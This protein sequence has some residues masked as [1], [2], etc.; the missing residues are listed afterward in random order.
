VQLHQNVCKQ[1]GKSAEIGMTFQKRKPELGHL[2]V[3]KLIKSSHPPTPS[4]SSNLD[5]PSPSNSSTHTHTRTRAHARAHTHTHTHKI[6]FSTSSSKLIYHSRV[7]FLLH[8]YLSQT[9]VYFIFYFKLLY[10]SY[11]IISCITM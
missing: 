6:T 5:D 4:V 2:Q 8:I 1:K 9:K 11:C 10:Y 3:A 7:S